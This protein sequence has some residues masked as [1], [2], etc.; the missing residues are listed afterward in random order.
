VHRCRGSALCA[1]V[2]S[3]GRHIPLIGKPGAPPSPSTYVRCSVM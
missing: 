3:E 1:S 2:T